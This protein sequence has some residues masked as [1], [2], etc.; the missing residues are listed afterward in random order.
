MANGSDDV[1]DSDVD[2]LLMMPLLAYVDASG[3]LSPMSMLPGSLVMPLGQFR[4]RWLVDSDGDA[5]GLVD[6]AALGRR[7]CR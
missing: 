1:G 4:C 3:L 2:G 7:R 6:D 5:S